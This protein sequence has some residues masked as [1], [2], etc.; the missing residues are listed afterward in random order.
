MHMDNAGLKDCDCAKRTLKNSQNEK[1]SII[2]YLYLRNQTMWKKSQI[3]FYPNYWHRHF[4]W[5]HFDQMYWISED[6]ISQS[7]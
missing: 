7:H 4:Q 1:A 6:I 5:H 2:M 3:G